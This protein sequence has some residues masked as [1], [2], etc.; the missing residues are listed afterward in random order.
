MGN[1]LL[2]AK[3]SKPAYQ[4]QQG[5]NLPLNIAQAWNVKGFN[6]RNINMNNWN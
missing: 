4:S 3:G 2:I 5:R 6:G 1:E